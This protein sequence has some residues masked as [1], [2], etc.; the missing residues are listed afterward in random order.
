MRTAKE[1]KKYTADLTALYVEDDDIL[2][3]GTLALFKHFF[4]EID[5]AVD[6]LDGL[7]KYNTK[8]YDIVITDINMPNMNGI[9]MVTRIKEINPEQKVIAISAHNEANI[10]I[11]LIQAGVN[12]FLLKP[13][14]QSEVIDVLYGISRDAYTQNLNIKLVEE[15]TEKNEKLEKQLKE[16]QVKNNTIDIK[17]SQLETLLQE[18]TDKQ[19]SNPLVSEYFEKDEDEGEENVVFI[20]DDP[21]D[22]LE[23]FHEISEHMPFSVI[24]SSEE[25]IEKI[26]DIF[27]KISTILLRYTPYLDSLS[28]SMSELSTALKEHRSE[29]I[30]V[31]KQDSD[32]VLMLFD[33][34]SSDME[35]YIERFSVESIAM[36]NSH[37]IHEPTILSIRQIIS[38][39][40]A[41][42]IDEGE[43]EFF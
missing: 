12:S 13:I 33:A 2:R 21:D 32:G 31:L 6:G 43:M 7:E 42:Q 10:L 28:A 27:S 37:H 15:L 14:I 35:R 39:F 9:E 4:K 17:H 8:S 23:Y 24:Y 16:L 30:D 36:K 25:E 20:N 22:L 34:V 29:F 18:K 26:A 41:D 11:P 1:L 3:E 5:P 19:D 38:L 40:I